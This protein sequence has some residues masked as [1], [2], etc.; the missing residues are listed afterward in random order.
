MAFLIALGTSVAYAA[1]VFTLLYSWAHGQMSSPREAQGAKRER[2]GR[3][4]RKKL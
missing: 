1:S 2:H 3:R 4:K